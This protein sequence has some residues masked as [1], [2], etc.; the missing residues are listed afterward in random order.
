MVE[1]NECPKVSVIVPV[2]NVQ[3]YLEE[4]LDSIVSQTLR[5]I[6]IICV[7]DGSTDRSAEILQRYAQRDTRVKLIHKPNRGYGHTIN[8]GIRYATGKYIGIVESDDFIRADMFEVL[9]EKAEK[10]SLDFIKSDF[11]YFTGEKS[12]RITERVMTCPRLGWYY[13]IWNASK[14]PKLLEANLMN[15]TGIYRLDF[16]RKYDIKLNETPGAAFQDTGFWFQ[17]FIFADRMMFIPH[18]FYYIRR[19]NPHSSVWNPEQILKISAEYQFVYNYLS[20][21]P[22]KY[23]LFSPYLFKKRISAYLFS[24]SNTS[25]ETKKMFMPLFS[26]EISEAENKKEISEPLFDRGTLSFM[27]EVKLWENN[28]QIPYYRPSR[29]PW[30]RFYDCIKENGSFYTFKHLLIKLKLIKKVFE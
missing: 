15:V 3:N 30:I 1:K 23:K 11:K 26:R 10:H 24:F 14:E 28:K 9:W 22:E 7:D 2:F 18:A 13:R 5:E 21:L 29:F 4:C 27:R 16:L 17:V 12:N 8:M 20:A 19:D 6:E 25:I